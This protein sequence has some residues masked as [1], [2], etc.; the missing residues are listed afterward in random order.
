[1]LWG[2]HYLLSLQCVG[3]VMT[4]D[5]W[6]IS[7]FAQS[8]L[9]YQLGYDFFRYTDI[10]A[11]T[12]P[13]YSTNWVSV[14]APDWMASSQ[15]FRSNKVYINSYFHAYVQRATT[16]VTQPN[17]LHIQLIIQYDVHICVQC[18]ARALHGASHQWTY[19]FL[20]AQ[21]TTSHHITEHQD[22]CP[23]SNQ[24]PLRMTPKC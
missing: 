19:S 20:S 9:V 1:M 17:Y 3:Q 12:C 13:Q 2:F 18:P 23:C 15:L 16:T 21:V 6:R 10:I 4:N 11:K 7:L 22:T 8:F 14:R 24:K 5:A